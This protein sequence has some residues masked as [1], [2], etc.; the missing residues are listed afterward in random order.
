[1]KSKILLAALIAGSAIVATH[2]QTISLW[3]FNSL[4]PD[5]NT[6]TGTLLPAT[7]SG[8]VSLVGGVTSTFAAGSPGDPASSGTDNS[9]LNL[10]TWAA[11]GTGSGTRG[12]QVAASTA[13]FS[14][15]TI[16][17]DFRQ[18]GTVSRY[19]QLQASSDGINFNNV[20]GGTTSFGTVGLGNTGTTFGSNGLYSNNPGGGSQTFV[21]SISYSFGSGSSYENNPNF[22]FRWVAVFEPVG[23]TNYI[24]ANAGTTA[25]YAATGTGRFDQVTVSGTVIPV[26]E[27]STLALTGLGFVGL[28]GLWRLKTRRA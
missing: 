1:M 13:G 17:L 16:S 7:G 10:T 3:N 21:Q 19:F 11:Q 12:L 18:S 15:I 2:A 25:A 5:T 6:A 28:A 27:P 9:G 23:G 24:S 8:T 22:A 4:T 14:D 20:S 26:P